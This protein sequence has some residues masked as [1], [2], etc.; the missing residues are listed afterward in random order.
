VIRLLILALLLSL[1]NGGGGLS[2]DQQQASNSRQEGAV[3]YTDL[4]G[5]SV[6][7]IET[8]TNNAKESTAD[9]VI[10]KQ[11]ERF[12]SGGISEKIP[13]KSG[14]SF[15]AVYSDYASDHNGEYSYLVGAMVKDGTTPPD[16]M[17]LKRIPAGKYAVFTSDKGPFA[18]VVSAA[19]RKIVQLEDEGKIKRSYHADFE[20]YDQRSQDPQNAQIDVYIGLK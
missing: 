16:G 2:S 20:V 7:G 19:W 3:T 4:T 5:F 9:G 12:F 18:K 17:V 11:W 13:R 10:P 1:A 6:I 15:Y 8:R 14:L